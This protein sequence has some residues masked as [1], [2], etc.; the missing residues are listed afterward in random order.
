MPFTQPITQGL[1]TLANETD[2]DIF[3]PC[4]RQRLIVIRAQIERLNQAPFSAAREAN[5]Q[6][7]YIQLSAL[8]A[9]I[10]E[11]LNENLEHQC[12]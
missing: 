5:R 11:H 2:L 3:L 10:T 1:N 8:K 6:C 9:M 4:A 12:R 7:L